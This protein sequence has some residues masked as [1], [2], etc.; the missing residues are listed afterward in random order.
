[1]GAVWYRLFDEKDKGYGYV[2]SSTPELGIAVCKEARGL[3]LGTL[4][5]QKIIQKAMQEGYPSISLSV[6][7]ENTTAVHLY[8][9]LGF[10]EVGV[11]GT[12]ITMVSRFYYSK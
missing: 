2:D 3:G 10:K 9:K 4:L 6:D 11:E 12:S 1:M 5:M 8:K 7:P